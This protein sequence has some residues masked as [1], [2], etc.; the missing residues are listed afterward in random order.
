MSTIFQNDSNNNERVIKI[1]PWLISTVVL[2]FVCFGIWMYFRWQQSQTSPNYQPTLGSKKATL[3]GSI[4]WSGLQPKEGDQGN[5]SIMLRQAGSSDNFKD[6]GL[7]LTLSDKTWSFANAIEGENYEV[8]GNLTINGVSIAKSSIETVTAP[9]LNIPIDFN[10]SWS[11]LGL[12]PGSLQEE[13]KTVSGKYT[14]NGYLPTGSKLLIQQTIANQVSEVATLNL[15][16]NSSTF[17]II[18]IDPY[19]NYS[20]Q[21]ILKDKNNNVIGQSDHIATAKLGNKQ[22]NFVINS[23]AHPP[24]TA[25]PLQPNAVVTPKTTP[26]PTPIPTQVGGVILPPQVTPYPQTGQTQ[27][28]GWITINGPLDKDSRV[29]IMGKKPADND[30]QVWTTINNPK[31]DGQFW[32]YSQVNAGEWYVIKAQL[33]VREQNVNSSS[34][35][36]VAAPAGNINFTLN[37]NF[38]LTPPENQVA[39]NVEPC[40][41]SGERWFTYINIAK[42][43]QAGQYWIKVGGEQGSG[44]FYNQKININDSGVRIKVE[45]LTSGVKYVQFSYSLCRDCHSEANF[46]P[47]SKPVSFDC[48]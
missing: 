28:S 25:A 20:F 4:T 37:T 38:S 32:S 35:T 46:S 23:T 47:W 17:S 41:R 44:N 13:L 24:A 12:D 31:S 39:I 43:Q 30:Y 19:T 14:I 36:T 1:N 42:F 2:I 7:K 5:I 33:Q 11:D 16:G 29:Q 45:N 8:Y 15:S 21:A 34:Q 3:S 6:A 48:H 40:Q 10:V 27:V 26:T 9:A 18:N 22:I